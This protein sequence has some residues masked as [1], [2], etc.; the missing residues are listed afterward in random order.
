MKNLM[1]GLCIALGVGCGTGPEPTE[2]GS[3]QQGLKAGG[4]TGFECGAEP[5][6]C[7]CTPPSTSAD[8]QAMAKNCV[9]EIECSIL[10]TVCWC[11]QESTPDRAP[12][13]PKEILPPVPGGDTIKQ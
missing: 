10:L 13:P 6:I 12:T 2:L 9:G 3:S 4:G 5:G 8:C 7:T 11:I 1:L